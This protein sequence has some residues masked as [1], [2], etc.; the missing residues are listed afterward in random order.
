MTRILITGGSSYFGQH[1][2]PEAMNQHVTLKYSY[3]NNDPLCLPLGQQVDIREQTEV[4]DFVAFLQPDVIIHTVGS[5]RGEHYED[6]IRWGTQNIVDAARRI[7][8]RLIHI[9]TDAIFDGTMSPYDE[10]AVPKPVNEYGRA[11]ADAEVIVGGYDNHV[12]VRTSLIYGLELMDNSTKWMKQAL[13]ADESVTLFENQ[14]RNP[15]W[16]KTLS[17]AC[18]EL[19]GHDFTGILNVAGQ[20]T[21]TRADFALKMLDW[22]KITQRDSLT[23]GLA[24]E[25]SPLDCAMDVS[26]ATAVLQTPMFGVDEVLELNRSKVSG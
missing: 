11:K 17:R 6:V 4:F 22:W 20:Q 14:I 13:E 3:F 12:I 1:L 7:R 25:K 16:A 26:L 2:V 10:T 19:V 15:V 23:I 24:D 9:S 21:L 8:A 18:L 5:N